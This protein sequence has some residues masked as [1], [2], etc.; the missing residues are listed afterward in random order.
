MDF[1][2]IIVT[3]S[4]GITTSEALAKGLA[5]IVS[6]PIPGQEEHNVSYLLKNEAVARADEPREIGA[7][8]RDL[9]E[10]EK[11]MASL[12]ESAKRISSPDSSLRIADLI[13]SK[14]F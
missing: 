3:K 4:G 7:I 5:I 13:L 1:A 11:K 6:N 2:D 14:A 12:K 9:L 10:D 8:A